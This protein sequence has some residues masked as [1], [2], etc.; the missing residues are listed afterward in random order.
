MQTILVVLEFIL[1]FYQKQKFVICFIKLTKD[2][3]NRKVRIQLK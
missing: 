1:L 3:F 2:I